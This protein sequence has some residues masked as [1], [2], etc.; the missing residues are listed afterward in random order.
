MNICYKDFPAIMTEHGLNNCE[1]ADQTVSAEEK[2]AEEMPE[3]VE[4]D[5]KYTVTAYRH[6]VNED[7]YAE[8]AKTL[9]SMGF[10]VVKKEME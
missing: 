6:N 10:A 2:P 8:F 4:Q 7:E 1:K 3:A 5:V 9:T